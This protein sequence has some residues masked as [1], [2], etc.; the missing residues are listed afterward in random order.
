M[1]ENINTKILL[2]IGANLTSI[3]GKHIFDSTSDQCVS[4]LYGGMHYVFYDR[5][6]DKANMTA[7]HIK[8]TLM[9]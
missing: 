6:I 9:T 4:A 3:I 5:K 1:Q 2:C 7:L 8:D